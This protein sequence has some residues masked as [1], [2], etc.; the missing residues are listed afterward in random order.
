[1]RNALVNNYGLERRAVKPSARITDLIT[2]P[3]LEEGWPFLQ[4]F[5]D[6][7]TP[8]YRVARSVLGF[9]LPSNY[10]TVREIVDGLIR[11]N[12]DKLELPSGSD[13]EIWTRLVDVFV[14]QLN[15]KPEEVY[16]SASITQDLGCD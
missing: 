14:R 1:M 13:E 10:L 6:L 16:R 15:V 4:L 8:P 12:A 9:E 5:I 11:V 2:E 3:Q 7:D